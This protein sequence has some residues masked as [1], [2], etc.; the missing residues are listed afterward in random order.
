MLGMYCSVDVGFEH[1]LGMLGILYH[2]CAR[3]H[4]NLKH[5]VFVGI[6]AFLKHAC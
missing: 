3:N 6:F 4:E 1:S 2:P 5:L